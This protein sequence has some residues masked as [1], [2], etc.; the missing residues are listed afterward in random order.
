MRRVLAFS[1]L[2]LLLPVSAWATGINLI[3]NHGSISVS[4]SG[5]VSVGSQLMAFNGITPSPNHSLGGVSF[6][7]G[8][9]LTNCNGGWASGNSTFSGVG[10]SFV[11]TGKGKD[12]PVQLRT[13]IFSGSF[14]GDVTWTFNG[15]DSK[16][17][18]S[19]TLSGTIQGTLWDG[20]VVTGTTTQ[21]FFSASGQ[22][23]NGI[24]HI[25]VGNTNLPV[26]EPSTL[27]LLG[28]GLLGVAG[29]VRR[30]MTSRA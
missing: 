15:K 5:V 13:V 10:S 27:G 28:T 7:T 18:L 8:A 3:N 19:Y 24:G 2:A 16:G 4:N 6:S 26:P 14:V 25:D 22:I 30:R 17:R 12:L 21:N 23:N 20:R 11:V 9:C 29:M 1:L